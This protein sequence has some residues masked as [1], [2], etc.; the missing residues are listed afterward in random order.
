MVSLNNFEKELTLTNKKL[1]SDGSVLKMTETFS[2]QGWW[3]FS[4]PGV[5][6][7]ILKDGQKM[8][9]I[10]FCNRSTNAY[11]WISMKPDPLRFADDKN[12]L[13]FGELNVDNRLLGRGIY[14]RDGFVTIGYW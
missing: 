8:A 11:S 4:K 3:P 13:S 5:K 7:D 10:I 1:L 14:F 6:R 9:K 2:T 12:G